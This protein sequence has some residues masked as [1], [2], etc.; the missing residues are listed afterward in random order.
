MYFRLSNL[1]LDFRKFIHAN[2]IIWWR[3]IDIIKLTLYYMTSIAVVYFVEF[4]G[5]FKTDISKN[6]S[7]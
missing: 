3:N 5:L 6:T 1:I 4:A 2:L 7:F